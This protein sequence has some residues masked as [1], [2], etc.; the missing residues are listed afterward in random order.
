[1][2]SFLVS[3]VFVMGQLKECDKLDSADENGSSIEP[4][5]VNV[6]LYAYFINITAL[7]VETFCSHTSSCITI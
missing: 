7:D 2:L 5:K 1:M 6:I 4:G 3:S